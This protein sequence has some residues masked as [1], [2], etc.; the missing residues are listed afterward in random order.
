MRVSINEDFLEISNPGGFIEGI[1]ADNLLDAEPHGRNPIL[2]D[3]MKRIGLAERTGRGI[4][5]IFE[6]SLLFGRQLPDYS[7][8]STN[9]VDLLISKGPVD[10]AF[11][12]MISEEQTRI[13][14]SLPIYSLMI[15]N[16]LKSLNRASVNELAEFIHTNENRIRPIVESLLESGMVEAS[17]TGRGRTYMLSSRYYKLTHKPYAYVRNHDI[18]SMRHEELVIKLAKHQGFISRSDVIELLHV[19]P[20]QAYYILKK[21]VKGGHLQLLGKGAASKYYP[22]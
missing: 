18:D 4:D 15:L 13:G 17:G 9:N 7:R 22:I 10:K 5:R 20:A 21:L 12:Q 6:G 1:C 19:S 16:A 3:A 8:S 11:V 14:H 2:A